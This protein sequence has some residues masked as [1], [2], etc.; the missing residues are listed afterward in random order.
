MESVAV[1]VPTSP[2]DAHAYHLDPV[3]LADIALK[4]R[5]EMLD[6]ELQLATDTSNVVVARSDL[7][8]LVNLT[9]SYN[10]SGLGKTFDD[11]FQ[12]LGEKRYEDHSVGLHVEIPI[13]NEVARSRLRRVLASRLQT[14]ATRDQRIASIR[15]EVFDAADTLATNWER[16]LAAQARVV[17]AARVVD[18]ETRALRRRL[19]HVDRSAGC[20]NQ[21]G[22]CGTGGGVGR[23]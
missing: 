16:I 8:P 6:L 17:A 10:V 22:G 4:T 7:L 15:Q 1:L 20:A 23:C 11:S 5:M 13:G 19:A 12:L 14:L 3:K 18:T 2:P 9:Y 21:A